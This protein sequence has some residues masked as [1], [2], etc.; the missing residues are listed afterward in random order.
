MKKK[1]RMFTAL[2]V[3]LLAAG[4]FGCAST[5]TENEA[6]GMPANLKLIEEE[7]VSSNEAYVDDEADI[8][9]Y[10]VEVYQDDEYD[11]WVYASSNSAFFEPVQHEWAYDQEITASDVRI[12]WTTM[13]GNP[14]P[15]E[16]DQLAI[17]NVAVLADDDEQLKISFVNQGIEVVEGAVE[18][19]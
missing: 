10:T 4:L 2:A 16:D 19:K 18:G 14:E 7:T 5:E 11:I 13:M 3:S 12:T 8:V 15:T 9:N 17:A 1:Q 6:G